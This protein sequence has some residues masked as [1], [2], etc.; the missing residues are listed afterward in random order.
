MYLLIGFYNRPQDIHD[1]SL[2]L[3]YV[4]IVKVQGCLTA[5]SDELQGSGTNDKPKSG[6]NRPS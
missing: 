3:A 6:E 2:G 1:L 4:L 5:K